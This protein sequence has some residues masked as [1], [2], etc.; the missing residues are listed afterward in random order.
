MTRSTASGDCC[1]AGPISSPDNDCWPGWD[2]GTPTTNILPRPG[3]PPQEIR[4]L[5]QAP[6]RARAEQHFYRWLTY[7]ADTGG[8]RRLAGALSSRNEISYPLGGIIGPATCDD[9]NFRVFVTSFQPLTS[10]A[11]RVSPR[12][13]REFQ[14]GRSARS[15]KIRP[16]T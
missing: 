5:Y 6:D 4:L 13:S 10:V 12:R 8:M 16:S 15:V 11:R 7:C 14:K 9:A 1:V 3:S 2:A